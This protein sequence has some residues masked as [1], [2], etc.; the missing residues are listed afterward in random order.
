MLVTLRAYLIPWGS[1]TAP[2][3]FDIANLL[4]LAL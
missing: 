1:E 2:L 4:L 3:W